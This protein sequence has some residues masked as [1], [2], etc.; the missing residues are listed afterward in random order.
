MQCIYQADLEERGSQVGMI[1]DIYSKA[2]AVWV[3]LGP[4]D[5]TS[6]LAMDI[7]E[8][9]FDYP[10]DVNESLRPIAWAYRLLSEDA[11]RFAL[12]DLFARSYWNRLWIIQEVVVGS[13]TEHRQICCGRKM[14]P[15]GN[16][17]KLARLLRYIRRNHSHLIE[18]Q[19]S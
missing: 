6:D 1:V 2:K 10:E 17:F 14:S 7:V 16:I 5:A 15:L 18:K 19:S 4:V 12:R 9:M 3:W 8:E 13:G 11:K